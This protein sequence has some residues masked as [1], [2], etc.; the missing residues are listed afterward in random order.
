M[1][2]KLHIDVVHG[3]IDVDGDTDFVKQVYSDFRATLLSRLQTSTE[4]TGDD[5]KGKQKPP[6]KSAPPKPKKPTIRKRVKKEVDAS[7]ID[8]DHPKLDKSLDTSGLAKFYSQFEPKNNAEK[9]LIFTKFLTEELGIESPNTD[10]YYTCYSHLKE[11]IPKVFAQAF[12]DAHGRS[13]GYI[14][15]KSPSDI[16]I[17]IIGTNHF[18]D[19]IKKKGA[20]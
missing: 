13:Y 10:H 17:T 1:Q 11:R 15:Y 2:T 14:D 4:S 8:P 19:G 16:S 6:G 9:I 3:T 12:R 7:G 20:E 18:N 5:E